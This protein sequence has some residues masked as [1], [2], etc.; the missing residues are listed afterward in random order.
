[1]R[2]N[3]PRRKTETLR[4]QM[5]VALNLGALLVFA[6]EFVDCVRSLT[7]LF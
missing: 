1:M 2:V 4:T 6:V 3:T 7:A 5:S